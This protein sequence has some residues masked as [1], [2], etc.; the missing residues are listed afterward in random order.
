MLYNRTYH[1]NQQVLYQTA[2]NM[3][4]EYKELLRKDCILYHLIYS[5]D[6]MV[7]SNVGMHDTEGIHIYQSKDDHTYADHYN[8][9]HRY[10]SLLQMCLLNNKLIS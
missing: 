5:R 8:M 4:V 7:Y 2:C 9:S 1:H 6:D 3:Q 10:K